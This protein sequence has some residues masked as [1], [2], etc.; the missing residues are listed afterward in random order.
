MLN[1]ELFASYQMPHSII[2]LNSEQCRTVK[3]S[4]CKSVTNFDFKT[5][6]TNQMNIDKGNL[7]DTQ[8]Y[9]PVHV[10]LLFYVKL[11]IKTITI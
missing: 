6:L 7:D 10:I 8:T 5:V 3:L 2:T 9:G 4:L 11:D 1:A